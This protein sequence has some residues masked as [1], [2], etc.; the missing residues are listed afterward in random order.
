MYFKIYV[1]R[2][3][4]LSDLIYTLEDP[5]QHHTNLDFKVY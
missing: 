3:L 4:V 1:S 2:S 5:L